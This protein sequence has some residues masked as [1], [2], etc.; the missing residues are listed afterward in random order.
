MKLENYHYNTV[1]L[2]IVI[3]KLFG[4]L[5]KAKLPVY[6]TIQVLLELSLIR[7]CDEV[8]QLVFS[9]WEKY[10]PTNFIMLKHQRL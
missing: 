8:E 2:F 10:Y 3:H 1:V 5:N 6:F 9:E 7:D 4:K